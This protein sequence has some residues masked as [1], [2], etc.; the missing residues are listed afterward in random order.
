MFPTVACTRHFKMDKDLLTKY[1]N[2]KP[3]LAQSTI[4]SDNVSNLKVF[5]G[6][7]FSKYRLNFQ[8]QLHDLS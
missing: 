8:M 2:S 3:S 1:L 7:I 6:K 4:T 5:K